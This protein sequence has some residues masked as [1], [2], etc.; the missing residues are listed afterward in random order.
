MYLEFRVLLGTVEQRT[1]VLSEIVLTC[2]MLH[3][4]MRT[5][6]GGVDRAPNPVDNIAAIENEAA[7]Y[8]PDENYR[9]PSRETKHQ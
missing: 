9:N 3:N 1:K 7:V 8:V 2:V 4:I 6:Q 5:H